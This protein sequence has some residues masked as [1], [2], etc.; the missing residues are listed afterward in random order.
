MRVYNFIFTATGDTLVNGTKIII[1]IWALHRNPRYWG[2]D[3]E[4]FRPER[5]LETPLVHPS[6]YQPFSQFARSCL[7]NFQNF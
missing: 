7:G 1:N 6:Q 3:A 5:F 4:Q 2:D